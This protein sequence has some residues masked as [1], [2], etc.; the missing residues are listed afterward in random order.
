[1]YIIDASYFQSDKAIPNS[2]E[3]N[4]NV[5]TVLEQFIDNKVRLLLKNALGYEL[6]NDLDSNITDGG[7]NVGAP[8]K[9]QNFVNGVEYTDG[10]ETLKWQGLK[11]TEGMVKHSLLADFVYYYWL[12][13]EAIKN[14]GVGLVTATSKN[15]NNVS[16]NSTLSRHWNNFVLQYQG[17]LNEY[18]HWFFDR[19]FNRD[20]NYVSLLQ[21]LKDNDTDYPDATL[22]IYNFKNEFGI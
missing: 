14:T 21:F 8:V 12:E 3:L 22:R 6:F 9:W 7:L 10:T 13:N 2:L 19:L 11:F 16:Y 20:Y 4:S 18:N 1:M 15:A 5:N 17:E